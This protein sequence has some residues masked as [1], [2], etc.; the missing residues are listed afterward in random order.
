MNRKQFRKTHPVYDARGKEFFFFNYTFKIY[1]LCRKTTTTV[2]FLQNSAYME[3][4]DD[5]CKIL[6]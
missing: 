3:K 5:V 6:D 1:K 4:K 2:L